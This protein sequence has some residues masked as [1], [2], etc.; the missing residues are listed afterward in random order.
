MLCSISNN[1]EENDSNKF[2]ADGS[3]IRQAI[4]GTYK[5]LRRNSDELHSSP[6]ITFA[7]TNARPVDLPQ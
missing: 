5:E 6:M 4:D 1:R 7:T 3:G 2:L